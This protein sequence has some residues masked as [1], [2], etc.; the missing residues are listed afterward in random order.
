M[1]FHLEILTVE[2]NRKAII[3][4]YFQVQEEPHPRNDSHYLYKKRVET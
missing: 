2:N 1:D 3:Q 4:R